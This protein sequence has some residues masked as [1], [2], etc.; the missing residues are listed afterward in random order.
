MEARRLQ[1]IDGLQA[2]S[3][4]LR[5]LELERCPRMQS[6]AAVGS[7]TR[8]E[9]LRLNHCPKINRVD[10]LAGLGRLRMLDIERSAPLETLAPL[11]GHGALEVLYLSSV[12]DRDLD[13]VA[14]MPNLK[15][16]RAQG[17]DYN[18]DKNELMRA[19]VLPVSDPIYVDL[20]RLVQG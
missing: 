18:R 13:P 6:I 20:P 8:L 9:Y 2:V 14:R 7:A 11:S 1:S 10:D 19:G 15:I 12:A 5:G 3:G 16:L 17:A 4:S